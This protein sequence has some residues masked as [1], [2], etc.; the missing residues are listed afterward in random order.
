MAITKIH[1]IKTTVDKAIA[2]I[3]NPGKT[4]ESIYISSFACAPETAAL[5]FKYTLDH[6]AEQLS[7]N[8]IDRENKAFHLIQAFEPGEVSYEEAHA[9]GKELADRLLGGR[10]SYVLATHIDKGH[11]HSHIIFCA[12]DNLDYKH[13]HDCKKNYWYIRSLS[14]QLCKEHGLSVIEPS[15]KRGVTYKEWSSNKEEKSWKSKLRK[16]INQFIK[17]SSSYE[18]FLTLMTARGYEL[19]NTSLDPSDGKYIAFRPADRERFVRG[20]TRS[21]GKNYTKEQINERIE[22]N[23][24]RTQPISQTEK[25]LRQLIDMNNQD[26]FAGKPGLQKWASKENLKIAAETYS[27]MTAK[28]I[29][30]FTELADRISSLQQLSKTCND[31]ILSIEQQLRDLAEVI[32][33]ARQY[34][35]NK[36]VHDRYEKVKDQDC[37]F[38]KYE[39][40]IILFSGAE[41][42]LNRMGIDPHTLDLEKFHSQYEALKAQKQELAQ[43]QKAT[44]TEIRKL[45]LIEKNMQEYLKIF[46]PDVKIQ[47]PAQSQDELEK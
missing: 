18:E 44:R 15:E 35:E 43:Q 28:N 42:M 13:Y 2:Y 17:L 29:H 19:K 46:T 30:N 23:K 14:D 40:Q 32:K 47:V 7:R 27:R 24:R 16:D 4:D 8:D 45:K 21:L 6:T 26:T 9:I 36:S 20:S 39:S 1:G 37:F 11:V 33:Y 34:Q 22:N 38:R 10:Y 12:A 3:C 31:S 5:D 41:R 25:R